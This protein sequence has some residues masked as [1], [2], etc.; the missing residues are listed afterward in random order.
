MPS[1]S[2][3][4]SS[5]NMTSK[6]HLNDAELQ[7]L[8]SHL[9]EWKETSQDKRQVLLKE[10]IKKAKV[11]APKMPT[12]QLLKRKMVGSLLQPIGGKI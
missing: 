1:S 8:Q 3:E 12:G 7:V 5:E 10:I 2:S 11:H 4:T 6:Q 9:Q